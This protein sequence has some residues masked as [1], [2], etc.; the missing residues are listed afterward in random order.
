M[1]KSVEYTRAKQLSEELIPIIR[2]LTDLE[3]GE[4]FRQGLLNNLLEALLDL[5]LLS[6]HP[7]IAEFLLANKNR[8]QIIAV[9]HQTISRRYAL[10]GKSDDGRVGFVS[11]SPIQYFEDGVMFLE[12]EKPFEGHLGLYRNNHLSYAIMAKDVRKGDHAGPEHFNF[13][14]IE[15]FKKTQDRMSNSDLISLDEPIVKLQELLN[16]KVND[17]SQYQELLQKYPWVWGAQYREISRHAA[18]DDANIPD[19]TG[20]R[21]HDGDRDIFELKPPFMKVSTKAGDFSREF[22]SAW[23][24]AERYLNFVREEKDYLQRKGRRFDNP[25]CYLILGYD[26]TD[27]EIKLFRDKQRMSPWIQLFT[28]N[29][30]LT[31]MTETIKLVR[32]LKFQD[33]VG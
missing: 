4:L 26:L 3:V 8:S 10:Q 32:N 21:V 31:L 20:V 17:E 19:F 22:N 12:S 15:D 33:K 11:P 9:L 25:K 7:N 27:K 2:A 5:S 24:Q 13:V 23:N 18:L 14:D 29:D 6:K 1:E 28:F 16:Q 30:I